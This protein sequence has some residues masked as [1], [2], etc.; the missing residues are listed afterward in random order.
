MCLQI[1]GCTETIYLAKYDVDSAF[2]NLELNW[3]SWNSTVLKATSPLDG[4]V[5]YFVDKC[6]PFGSSISCALFQEVSDAIAFLTKCCTNQPIINYLDDYLFAALMKAYCNWQVDQFIQVC[7]EIKM[8]VSAKKTQFAMQSIVFLGFLVDGKNRLVLIPLEKLQRAEK[9]IKEFPTLWKRKTTVLCLQ[10]FC[11]FFNFL[12]RCV[13]S[14]RAF[15][16]W[17]Y[18]P[19]KAYLKPHH[20]IRVT[21]EM[22][23]D[24]R[25]WQQ[26]LLHPSTF[27]CP[28]TDFSISSLATEVELFSDA[29]RNFELSCGGV[30][31]KRDW[32]FAGRDKKFMQRYQ[33]S[34]EY[35]ELYAVT[36][37]VVLW[38]C[39]F[40]HRKIFLF[41]NNQAVVS[42]INNSTSSCKNCMILIRIIV[43]QGLKWNVIIKVQFICSKSNARMDAISCRK[44]KL[45]PQL[46]DNQANQEPC[47]LLEMLWPM[48]RVWLKN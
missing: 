33:P 2:R 17:L 29:S 48:S 47:D 14:G 37:T 32:F 46:S 6:L 5:Y 13:I 31:R 35:L 41:C 9:L 24:L 7:N 45:F 18:A 40:A 15:T 11:R 19:I 39:R 25:M 12:Y 16:P 4:Q 3:A 23:M 27:C 26:F 22:K 20:H 43:L 8:P 38:I 21:G 36:V 28:F 44:F 1:S 34:I 42:M 30:C 10:Q